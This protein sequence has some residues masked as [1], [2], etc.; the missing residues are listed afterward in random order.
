MNDFEKLGFKAQIIAYSTNG[1]NV[2]TTFNLNYPR[3]IHAELLTHRVFSKNSSS[4]RAIP[5]H[6]MLK[7]VWSNPAMPVHWGA[8]RPGMQATEELQG[9]RLHAA[10]FIWRLASKA[11]VCFSWLLGKI[12]LHKQI[13]NRVTEPYQWMNVVL[14][15]TEFDNFYSLRTHKDAQPEFRKLAVMMQEAQKTNRPVYRPVG[16]GVISWH[17]PYITLIE[18]LSFPLDVLLQV[19]TARCARVSYKLFDGKLSTPE[20]DKELYVKL[21]GSVPKHMSPA[22]HQAQSS[23]PSFGSANFRGWTQHRTFLES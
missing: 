2:I 19:S 22:E 13:A 16:Q 4:S 15:G 6:V 7:S 5:I 12:G 3:F 18:R 23:P 10:K 20:K 8:N 1:S 17:L 14:T 11:A 9:W 21:V